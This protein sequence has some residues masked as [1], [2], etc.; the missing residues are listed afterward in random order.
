MR[1]ILI[2][3]LHIG[4]IGEDTYGV[5]VRQN[6]LDIKQAIQTAAPDHIIIAGDLCYMDAEE[7]T[8]LWIKE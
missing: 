8:Y 5:D 4:T 6:F 3:D 2:T 7:S 1:V